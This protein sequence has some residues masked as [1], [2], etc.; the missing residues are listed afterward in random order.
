MITIIMLTGIALI[1]LLI[2]FFEIRIP[3]IHKNAGLKQKSTV[4]SH[5]GYGKDNKTGRLPGKSIRNFIKSAK[6]EVSYRVIQDGKTS[7]LA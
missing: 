2:G 6:N 4:F 3:F 7:D 5:A 1:T